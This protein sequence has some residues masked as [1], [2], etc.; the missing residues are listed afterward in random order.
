MQLLLD[1]VENAVICKTIYQSLN[2]YLEQNSYFTV[3]NLPAE[4]YSEIRDDLTRENYWSKFA[5]FMPDC[6]IN[7]LF[8]EGRFPGSQKLIILPQAEIPKFVKSQTL[9]SP[10]DLYQKY[11]A[12]DAKAL[13]SIQGLAALNIHLSGDR[14]ISKNALT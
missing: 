12:T 10:T 11:K 13:V 5:P 2:K 14:T 8:S 3:E 6:W 9:L 1:T 7:F 4:E